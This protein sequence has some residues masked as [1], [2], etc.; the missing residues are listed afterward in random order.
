MISSG[1]LAGYSPQT[2]WLTPAWYGGAVI[3]YPMIQAATMMPFQAPHLRWAGP[4]TR[5]P[6]TDSQQPPNTTSTTA[7]RR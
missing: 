2:G 7:T 6:R 3:A 4:L 5:C 1:A